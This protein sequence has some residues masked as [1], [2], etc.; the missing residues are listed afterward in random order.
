[1]RQMILVRGLPGSGKSTLA[2]LIGFAKGRTQ[3]GA[4][5]E[6]DNF[7]VGDD[8]V[9]R[10]DASQLG[11]AHAECIYDATHDEANVVIVANTFTQRWEMEPYIEHAQREGMMLTIITVETDL[12]DEQLAARNVHG[13]PADAIAAMRARFEHNPMRLPRC[14]R[15]LSMIGGVATRFR[16]GAV[17]PNKIQ[18]T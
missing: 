3:D 11:K 18:D 9:Y 13:V 4:V 12:T 5:H 15:G 8:G 17:S 2:R 14:E 16:R 7:F 1:M 6:A 10:F